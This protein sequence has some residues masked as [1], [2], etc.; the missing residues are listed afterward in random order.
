MPDAPLNSPKF[1]KKLMATVTSWLCTVCMIS[2][3]TNPVIDSCARYKCGGGR[4]SAIKAWHVGSKCTPDEHGPQHGGVLELEAGKL[5]R[6]DLEVGQVEAPRQGA[7]RPARPRRQVPAE[8]DP[9]L[10][11]AQGHQ[12][13]LAPQKVR[14]SSNTRLCEHLLV[15]LRRFASLI[16]VHTVATSWS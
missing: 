14:R 5:D 15:R 16:V 7:R 8:A 11:V 3:R 2:L 10:H 13:H 9:R 1:R 6:H 4:S 12:A